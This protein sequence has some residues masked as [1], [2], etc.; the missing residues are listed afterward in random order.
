[1]LTFKR[2]PVFSAG[3]LAGLCE[4]LAATVR[5][6]DD[7]RALINPG[8][9]FVMH[10]YDNRTANYG[11]QLEPGDDMAW[12]PGCSVCYLRL[13]RAVVEPEEGKYNLTRRP[14]AGL[15]AGDR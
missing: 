13:P 15:N 11:A 14:S 5:P 12:F 8:M 3:V 10:Y 2:G 1:M 7:G 9:G 4:L 6:A